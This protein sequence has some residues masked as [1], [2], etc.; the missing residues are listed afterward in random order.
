MVAVFQNK[1]Q[2]NFEKYRYFEIEYVMSELKKE[3][4]F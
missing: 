1:I 2:D 3:S 4:I